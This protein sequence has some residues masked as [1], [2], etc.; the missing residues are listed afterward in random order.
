VL[1]CWR[2]GMIGGGGGVM[3][4]LVVGAFYIIY[5]RIVVNNYF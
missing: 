5:D 2:G 4:I 3:W 1:P